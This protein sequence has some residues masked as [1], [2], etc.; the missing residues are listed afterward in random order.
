MVVDDMM[1][2]HSMIGGLHALLQ[3]GSDWAFAAAVSMQSLVHKG[4][5]LISS[6]K[7]GCVKVWDVTLQHCS[8]T[9]IGFK[10]EV[11]SLDVDSQEQRLVA[12]CVDSD[13]RV[14]V[15]RPM[16]DVILRDA[17]QQQQQQVGSDGEDEDV[18][19]ETLLAAAAARAAAAAADGQQQQ[20][21]QHD[22]LVPMGLV[23][24]TGQ[25]RV[26]SI[27]YS[28]TGQLL[29]VMGAGKGLEIFR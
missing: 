2:Q 11:W 24:R 10:G 23:R 13:L 3:Q 14:Y 26:A 21:R 5:K 16:D 22:L 29:G 27:R 4:A 18:M 6:S 15:I 17:P 1:A 8:Q 12:G 28:A 19:P 20:R 7:D 25:E 9:I